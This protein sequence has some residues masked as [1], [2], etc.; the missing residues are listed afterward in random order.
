MKKMLFKMEDTDL[1]KKIISRENIFSAIYSLDSYIFEKSL[2]T[3]SDLKLYYCLKDKYNSKLIEAVIKKC[4]NKLKNI[5]D[6]ESNEFFEV[7]VFF[8]AKKLEENGEEKIIKCRPMH[9]ASLITQI[10]IV[11][12]LNVL[13]YKES[14]SGERQLSDL[15]QLIPSNFYGN[16]PCTKPENIFYNWKNKYKEYSENIIKTY[17]I[18]KNTSLYKYEVSLDLKNFFPSI[19]PIIIYNYVIE[20]IN[21]LFRN[22]EL[23]ALKVILK[24]LLYFD[25]LNLESEKSCVKYYGKNYEEK[26]K[27]HPN[28][29]IPQGLPQSYYFGNICMI[30][31]SKEFNDIFP[32]KSFFYVDDS[33]IYTNDENAS[34]DKFKDSLIRLNQKIKESLERYGECIKDNNDLT[35][36]ANRINYKVEVHTEDKS[37]TSEV[38]N[39]LKMNKAFLMPISLEASRVSFEVNNT[40]DTLEDNI[41]DKKID[42]VSKAI[43]KEIENVNKFKNEPNLKKEVFEDYLKYLKRYKKFFLYR[44]KILEFRAFKNIEEI[45]KSFEEKYYLKNNKLSNEEVEK[46]FSYFDEDI[47]LAEAQL[48]FLNIIDKEERKSFRHSIKKFEEML[49]NDVDSKNLY[50]KENFKENDWIINEYKSLESVSK[51]KIP[52]FLK[53]NPKVQ[54][55]YLEKI[56]DPKFIQDLFEYGKGYDKSVFNN[57]SEYQRKILNAY[58]SRV[59]NIDLSDDVAIQKEDRRNIKYYELRLFS[60]IRNKNCEIKKFTNFVTQLTS[61]KNH[62]EKIDFS[63]YEILHILIKY[64]KNPEYVDDLILVHKYVSSIWKNGSRFLYFYTLHNQEHSIELIKSVVNLCK[65]IDYF[66]IKNED[67]YIL[68]LSCYLHDISMV[69]Q[70]SSDIFID[71][72]SDTDEIYTSFCLQMDKI[73]KNIPER[74]KAIKKLMKIAF[75]TISSYFERITRDR[76]AYDSAAFI[77]SNSD[78]CFLNNA[79]RHFVAYV[80]EAHAYNPNDV[81]GLKSKAKIDNISEK[82]MMI[83]LRLADLIDGAKDR[84]SLNILKHNINNMPEISQYHWVTHAV[85]DEFKIYSSYE[86]KNEKEKY[87]KENKEKGSIKFNSI[88]NKENLI[89]TITI[90]I[91]LNESNLTKVNSLKCKNAE[92]IIDLKKQQVLVELK[93]N[94]ENNCKECNFLCKWILNKNYYLLQE[95]NALQ[96]Y[97]N[98]T[99]NNI[100]KT[101]INIKLNFEDSMPLSGDY[102]HIVNKQIM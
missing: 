36:L 70:P 100:F 22:N 74:K 17:D 101:K 26:M 31:I 64:V 68:F 45:K 59:F 3:E 8:K 46:V 102:Y 21:H 49:I 95:L 30:L 89:E 92:A 37:M 58:I 25:I 81:Y 51:E 38:M 55:E 29:G 43:D 56:L 80:S 65:T 61:N 11:C 14:K 96:T 87:T 50:F 97:L 42:V 1:Y 41:L 2:L 86:F 52:N 5:L 73:E 72:N 16:I 27:Y 54:F 94:E 78:L 12:I 62:Y 28:V 10:C 76:H 77:K 19:N 20:K 35:K 66:N 91:K 98:R 18:A 7:K 57:S 93:K 85:T 53:S 13:M 75:E 4:E 60:Y 67:Y 40:I 32:G 44:K 15:S 48:I 63:I 84:V 23:E 82:Y 34:D 6:S 47:F 39:S 69:L 79:I 90:E 24:K 9:T 33:V 88:L 83:L 71:E 99:S